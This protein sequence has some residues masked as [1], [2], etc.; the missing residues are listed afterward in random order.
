MLERIDS[1]EEEQPE[2]A[3]PVSF[4][5]VKPLQIADREAGRESAPVDSH[6]EKTL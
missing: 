2:N 6:S 5:I 3:L 1:R 4:I